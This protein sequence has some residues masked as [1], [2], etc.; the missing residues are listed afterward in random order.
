MQDRSI[1]PDSYFYFVPSGGS[2]YGD[3][4]QHNRD[5]VVVRLVN[6][7]AGAAAAHSSSSSHSHSSSASAGASSSSE[8]AEKARPGT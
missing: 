8:S 4:G 3:F 1:G 5:P 7:E 6:G 2:F